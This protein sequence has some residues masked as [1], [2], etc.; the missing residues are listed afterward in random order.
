MVPLVNVTFKSFSAAKTRPY[1]SKA[2]ESILDIPISA[3][4][5]SNKAMI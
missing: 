1:A 5:L 3:V 4:F 2:E